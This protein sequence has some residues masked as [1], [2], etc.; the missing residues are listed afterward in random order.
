MQIPLTAIL[1]LLGVALGSFLNVYIDRFPKGKSLFHPPSHCDA[2]QHRLSPGD[3]IPV[4][5]YLWLGGRCRYCHAPIPRT[6]LWVE[7]GSGALV[8][9]AYR[10]YDLS[11]GF[12]VT[13]L[14]CCLF[15]V[16]AVIDLEHKLILNRMLYP[17]LAAA[18]IISVFHPQPGIVDISLP[19]PYVSQGITGLVS[20]LMGGITG[21]L[22]LLI[23]ALVNPQGMGLGDVKLAALIGL[24]TGFPL[25]LVALFMGTTLGG[26]VAI[27]LLLFKVKKRKDAIPFA[28]FLSL[29]TIVTLLWGADILSWYSGV[30]LV[31]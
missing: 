10:Q 18:L 14:Y 28:P 17:A 22:F 13:T 26:L 19:W 4:F 21:F 23:P 16:I 25:V 5:S 1:A 7:I 31:P 6:Q 2:C 30:L 11:L 24:A 15:I 20:S 8:A 29:A 3:L 9:L 27:A 12:A